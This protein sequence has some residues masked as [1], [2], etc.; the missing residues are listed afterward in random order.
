MQMISALVEILLGIIK[1]IFTIPAWA[2]VLVI[3]IFVV[4]YFIG[5]LFG[6]FDTSGSPD[7]EGYRG[8]SN[9]T[10]SSEPLQ[11]NFEKP[12]HPFAFY[13][14]HGNLCGRGSSFYD[15]KGERCSWGGG[16]HDG[17]GCYRQWGES[18]YDA[19]GYFRSWGECFYDAK[20]NL[21]YPNW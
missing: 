11:I 12:E 2:G 15:S 19:K 7:G 4:L 20:G 17:K 18:Y 10:D 16:F 14:N 3:V 5:D 9:H 13:D 21:V 6:I 8:S 1:V